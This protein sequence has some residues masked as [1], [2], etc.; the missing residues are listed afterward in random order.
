M[1][2]QTKRSHEQGQVE[3]PAQPHRDHPHRHSS[4]AHY[5]ELHG[6]VGESEGVEEPKG[7]RAEDPKRHRRA[8]IV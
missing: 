1:N 5:A 4:H 8:Y 3:D 2:Q 6:G 7:R